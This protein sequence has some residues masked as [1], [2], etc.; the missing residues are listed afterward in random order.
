[1]FNTTRAADL[2][3]GTVR[4]PKAR[5]GLTVTAHIKPGPSQGATAP[6]P[7]DDALVRAKG[8]AFDGAAAELDDRLITPGQPDKG[9]HR[10][11]AVALF[12]SLKD[13]D[14]LPD[15][16]KKTWA[17][18]T[19][20]KKIAFLV[21]MRAYFATDAETIAH[22]K[23]LRRVELVTKGVPVDLILHDEAATRLEAVRDELPAGTMPRT[24]VGW[25]RGQPSLHER[26]GIWNLHDLGLAVDFNATET[27]NLTDWRQ[28]DLIL[29]V[30]GG[31]AWQ[32]GAWTEGDYAEMIK[33]TEE[34]APMADPA[35]TS[36]LGKK[37]AKAASEAQAA[38][39]RS[40]AFR[41]S[42][43]T[44]KLLELRARRRQNPAAWSAVDDAELATVITPWTKAV[45]AE[46]TAN[47]KTLQQAGFDVAHL[48]TG[49]ALDEEKTA[50]TAAAAAATSFR[51]TIHG[52]T[53]TDPQRTTADALIAKLVGLVGQTPTTAQTP[54]NDADRLKAIDELTAAAK[55][56]LGGYGAAGWRER[57][58]NLRTSLG[59]ASW[60]LGDTGGTRVVDPS[61]TQLADLG[62][63]TLKEHSHSGPGGT[64]QAG[65]FDIPF[66]KA[67]VKHG[68]NQLSNSAKPVD[69][70][71]FELRWRGSA[72]P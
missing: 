53:L 59:D 71:H 31:Q 22:F 23:R 42:V 29:L 15:V 10:S 39:N 26:A 38:S 54:A 65:A 34:R 57:V 8:F 43:D 28:K 52:D 37:I 40:E 41:A 32:S 51:K 67:M 69:S 46:L 5:L 4:I 35:A 16:V 27:P 36:D 9:T 70:M 72:R 60:V 6:A 45:D 12:Q 55:K 21:H 3:A 48:K 61:P 58:S 64:A 49:K 47:A 62:F 2:S 24:T 30:T 14:A 13:M 17:L 19:T 63:F 33:H 11:G 56:R 44:H 7:V 66:I 20:E 68:F 1:V 18:S 25:P 50:V